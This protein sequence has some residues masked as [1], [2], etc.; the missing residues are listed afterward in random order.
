M[1]IER[2]ALNNYRIYKGVNEILFAQNKAKNITVIAGNNGFGKTTFLASLVW[3]LYGKQI[4]DVDDKYRRDIA[5]A[6]GYKNYASQLLNNRNKPLIDE[7]E[8][9]KEERLNIKKQGYDTNNIKHKIFKSLSQLSVAIEFSNI[10]IPSLPCEKVA[11]KR[12]FDYFRETET[13]EILIDGEESQLTRDVGAEVFIND[14]I[15]PKDIAKFFFFD[16][17]R[18]VSLAEMKSLTDRRR[19]SKA[20][21]EVLGVRKYEDLKRNLENLRIKFRRKASVSSDG[22]RL[23]KL[24]TEAETL[25]V[26]LTKAITE[27]EELEADLIEKRHLSEQYQEKLI[28]EGNSISVSEL[29]SLKILRDTLIDKDKQLKN[30]LKEMLDLAPFAI[31]GS[32]LVSAIDQVEKESSY[33]LNNKNSKEVLEKMNQLYTSL[34][35]KVK[36]LKVSSEIKNDFSAIISNAFD[37][38][39]IETLASSKNEKILLSFTIDESN[40]FKSIYDNLKYSYS[41]VFKQL[42]KDVGN[43]RIFLSKTNKKISLAESTDD[44]PTIK[45]IRSEKAQIDKQIV[46]IEKNIKKISEQI[47]SYQ[48]QSAVKNKLISELSKNI[49][50][51]ETDVRKDEIASRLIVELDEFLLKLKL[52]KKGSLEHRIKKGL[53]LLMHKQD[54]IH[55]VLVEIKEDLIDIYLFNKESQE[56]DKE[57]LSKG[58][59]QLYATA[60]L[61]ALVDESEIEFPIFIDSPLQKFDKI[62]SKKIITEFYP[63]VSKQVILFPLLQKEL[64]EEEYQNLLPYVSNSFIIKNNDQVSEFL[65]AQPTELFNILKEENVHTY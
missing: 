47:G 41:K 7:F 23:D 16:S 32:K 42:I 9:S 26:Y 59:Q 31:S 53:N 5:E 46:D 61:K 30:E 64:T 1:Y 49:D 17:E 56:I 38:R 3:C 34:M 52:E 22:D 45:G 55:N 18:I 27:I 40:E 58:E 50:I 11:I 63:K 35:D 43:N 12:T 51:D 65:M 60:I 48:Q 14:F 24:I 19:L 28:R 21:S 54:F 6:G 29:K 39:E 62:H 8:L 57:S 4:A 44:N 36:N 13:I 20:Y 33:S 10:S 37:H 25:D 2:V 15:L